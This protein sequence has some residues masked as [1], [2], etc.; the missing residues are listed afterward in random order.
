[1]SRLFKDLFSRKD[2]PFLGD[3][4]D[5]DWTPVPPERLA[6]PVRPPV[7]QSWISILKQY[8]EHLSDEELLIIREQLAA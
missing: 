3:L 4:T 5:E 2:E 7:R 1:M 8:G 6:W